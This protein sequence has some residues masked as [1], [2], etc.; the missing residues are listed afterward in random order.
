[1]DLFLYLIAMIGGSI[2]YDTVWFF[3]VLGGAMALGVLVVFGGPALV[4]RIKKTR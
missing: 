2:Q 1:M 3:S 4:A